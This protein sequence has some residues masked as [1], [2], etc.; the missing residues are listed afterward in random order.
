MLE[1]ATL[2]LL[3]AMGFLA[4]MINAAVGSGSLLTLPVL[5][6]VGIPPGT[7][8]RTNTIGLM[9]STVGSALRYRREIAAE[10]REVRPLCIVTVLCAA[11]GSIL[12]L[13][14]PS[15]LLHWVVPVLIVLALALVVA[16]PRITATLQRRRR[17]RADGTAPPEGPSPSG[18]LRSPGLLASMAAAS[19]YGGYFTAAQGILYLGILGAFTGREMRDVNALKVLLSLIVNVIAAVVYVVSWAW[20]GA[21]VLWLSAA[22]LAVSSFLGGFIGGGVAKRLPEPAMRGVIIAVALIALMRQFL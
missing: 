9:F 7:A 22:V 12:L 8:V 10:G 17:A 20:F 19:A 1:P 15:S 6:A 13:L 4:G 3:A 21:Q 5:L 2:L 14:S 18:G 16:Q 11:T